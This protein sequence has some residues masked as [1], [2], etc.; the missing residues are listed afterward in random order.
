LEVLNKEDKSFRELLPTKFV[1]A[2]LEYCYGCIWDHHTNDGPSI[3]LW[4]SKIIQML[5]VLP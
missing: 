3:K 4:D 5:F 2:E 1:R